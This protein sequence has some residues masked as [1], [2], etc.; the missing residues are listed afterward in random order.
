MKEK[1]YRHDTG[2]TQAISSSPT[3]GKTFTSADTDTET[4]V[5]KTKTKTLIV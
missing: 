5:K 2:M 1:G 4:A 3:K